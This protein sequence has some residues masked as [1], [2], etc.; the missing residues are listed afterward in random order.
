M[1]H[2]IRTP[3]NAIIGM[4]HLALQD[5]ARPAAA[6]L[7]AKDPA[8]AASTCSASST[9][10]WTSRRS[11]PASWIMESIDFELEEVLDNVSSLIVRE[12]HAKGWS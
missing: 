9:T 8:I 5:R 6:R 3:M 4:S 11:K 1:S 12:G 2:E 10:S 7:R